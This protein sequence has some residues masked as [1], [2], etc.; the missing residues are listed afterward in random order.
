V[1][2]VLNSTLLGGGD[3]S[4]R[5]SRFVIID[6]EGA[7]SRDEEGNSAYG[8]GFHRVA[9]KEGFD[10][11]YLESCILLMQEPCLVN[12]WIGCSLRMK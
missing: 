10:D 8:D 9:P 7:D 6:E 11:A 3:G 4:L 5:S 12:P 2:E 1:T